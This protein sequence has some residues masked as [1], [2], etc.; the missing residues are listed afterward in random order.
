[1]VL[2][3]GLRTALPR[4]VDSFTTSQAQTRQALDQQAKAFRAQQKMIARMAVLLIQHDATV[5]GQN[6]ET[7]G[8][9]EELLRR[10]MGE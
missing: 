9:T 4:M 1:M 8:T 7:L 3:Y 5:R 6:P 2:W 10:V